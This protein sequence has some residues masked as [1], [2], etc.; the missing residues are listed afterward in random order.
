PAPDNTR[1]GSEQPRVEPPTPDN[2]RSGSEQPRVE[3]PAPDN[4]RSGSEQPRV[5]PPT[6]DNTRSGSEQLRVRG[7]GGRFVGS[8]DGRLHPSAPRPVPRVRPA[9][10]RVQRQPHRLRRRRPHRDVAGGVR[11]LRRDGAP[12]RGHGGGRRAR[13]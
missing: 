10:H 5:E 1:S 13:G 7:G 9:G 4:T 8:P 2:T 12:R 11:L 3:P 6:P